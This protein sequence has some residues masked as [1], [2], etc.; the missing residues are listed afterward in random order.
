VQNPHQSIII[1]VDTQSAQPNCKALGPLPFLFSP[2]PFVLNTVFGLLGPLPFLFSPLPFLFNPLPFLL[3]TVFG[4]LGPLPF[5][6]IFQ[7]YI[8]L[9]NRVSHQCFPGRLP[10]QIAQPPLKPR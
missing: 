9:I 10:I 4:L 7:P 3:N 1:R 6:L 5:L 2:L 8:T